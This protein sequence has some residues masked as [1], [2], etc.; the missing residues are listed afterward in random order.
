MGVALSMT[1]TE[2]LFCAFAAWSL[3]AVLR[4]QWLLAGVC[5]ASAPGLV[6]PTAARW[7]PPSGWPPSSRSS[8][9]AT[10]GG[11]GSV[12]CSRPCGL[13][14]YLG[15]VAL[16]D[17]FARPAGSAIQRQGWG[18]YLDGGAATARYT[19]DVCSAEKVFDLA[20]V[21]ALAASLVLF[22]VSIRMGLP[23]PLLVYGG[24]VSGD[25]LGFGGPRARQAAAAA[26]RLHAA[27]ARRHRPRATAH[28]HG[29]DRPGL[30]RARV[31]LVWRLCADDLALRH[32]TRLPR[33]T[34]L[35]G[36]LSLLSLLSGLLPGDRARVRR[37]R[38]V[39]ARLD[40]A[41]HRDDDQ[42]DEDH[43]Q[44]DGVEISGTAGLM[45]A[46]AQCRISLT[47]M[48]ARISASPVDR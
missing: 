6:R 45:S 36:L 44:R 46:C 26:A 35:P 43:P 19:V 1:Y 9:A 47:P 41:R 40:Q 20:I 15:Y 17:R 25:R 24:L 11:P 4:R 30:R 37:G 23:W 39:L 42:H 10:D 29:G 38:R 28:G 7:S 14:G 22:A 16:S 32:L 8:T 18:W 12:G 31:R 5:A 21:L 13:F 2:A 34:C 33:L 3:V 27:A 48:N